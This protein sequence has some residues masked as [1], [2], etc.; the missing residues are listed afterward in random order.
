MRPALG[1]SDD[2]VDVHAHL[3]PY[4]LVSDLDKPPELR[5]SLR[6]VLRS[7]EDKTPAD[8]AGTQVDEVS[9]RADGGLVP[10]GIG[11]MAEVVA[12]DHPLVQHSDVRPLEQDQSGDD[13][14]QVQS[15]GVLA[16][17]PHTLLDNRAVSYRIRP[18]L[19][20]V[21]VAVSMCETGLHDAERLRGVPLLGMRLRSELHDDSIGAR[22]EDV[23][24]SVEV[25]RGVRDSC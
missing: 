25:D 3:F 2:D 5:L 4:P 17:L 22:M 16:V 19:P 21:A 15:D 11:N 23:P 9:E 7:T 20:Q 10:G 24:A 8:D 18:A 12:E 6:A 14:E 1:R 13:S